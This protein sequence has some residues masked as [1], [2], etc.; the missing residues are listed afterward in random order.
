MG[1]GLRTLVQAATLLVALSLSGCFYIV[2]TRDYP[3]IVDLDAFCTSDGWW[4]LEAF[5]DHPEGTRFIDD[6]YVEVVEVWFAGYR[7]DQTYLGDAVLEPIGG[8]EWLGEFRSD[9]RFLDCSW[10][11]DYDLSFVAVDRDGDSDV[12]TI[13]R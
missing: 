10:P 12:R 5:V 9:P 7:E 3:D 13:T 6:V 11:W 4:V 1:I 8:G 2:E